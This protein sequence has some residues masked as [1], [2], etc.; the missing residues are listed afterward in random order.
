MDQAELLRDVARSAPPDS[1]IHKRLH[2]LARDCEDLSNVLV[3]S[4]EQDRPPNKG[5]GTDDPDSA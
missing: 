3:R 2:K 5:H 1:E 4:L